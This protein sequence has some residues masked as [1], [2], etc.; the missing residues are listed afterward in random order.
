MHLRARRD[1]PLSHLRRDAESRADA[2]SLEWARRIIVDSGSTDGTVERLRRENR[3]SLFTRTF[4][5]FVVQCQ[6]GLDETAIDTPWILSLD[7]DHVLTDAF[8]ESLR[9]LEP[10]Q[11]TSGYEAD[12]VYCI[13]GYPLRCGLYRRGSS[14]R[15]RIGALRRR[16]ACPT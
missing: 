15:G 9:N 4:D 13:D 10:A 11:S 3:V 7:S 6:F 12:F 2:G 1:Y 8:V 14:S 16:R 5:S